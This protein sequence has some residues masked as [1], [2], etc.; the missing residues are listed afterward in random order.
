[1][2][3]TISGILSAIFV[4]MFF[5]RRLRLLGSQAVVYGKEQRLGSLRM[6]A[7][8]G[9]SK[10]PSIRPTMPDLR[11]GRLTH[12]ALQSRSTNSCFRLAVGAL[13]QGSNGSLFHS[14][15]GKRAVSSWQLGSRPRNIL[16]EEFCPGRFPTI[17]Y[18]ATVNTFESK[19]C[20]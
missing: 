10:R 7:C 9:C 6:T 5:L 1:M 15:K 18:S 3:S 11:L 4:S 12:Q 13:A 14:F 8:L 20:A 2:K 16:R 19:F 17:F